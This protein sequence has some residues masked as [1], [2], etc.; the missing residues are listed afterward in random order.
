MRPTALQPEDQ[1][2]GLDAYLL[3]RF[4]L[5]RSTDCAGLPLPRI[6]SFPVDGCCSCHVSLVPMSCHAARLSRDPCAVG[7]L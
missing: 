3:H 7:S 4:V 6:L 1:E 5:L 2:F